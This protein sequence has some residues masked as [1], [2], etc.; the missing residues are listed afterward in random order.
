VLQPGGWLRLALPDLE[1]AMVAFLRKDARYFCVPDEDAQSL[2]GKLCVQMT[3]YGWSRSLFTGDYIEEL[4]VRAG[5]SA[6]HHCRFR[7]T[8][9]PY[10]G[11]VDLD[12]RERETLFTEAVS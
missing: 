10:P 8:R 7:E 2:G 11:I 1:R 12:N 3:W 9:S 5:F 4:L 6:V